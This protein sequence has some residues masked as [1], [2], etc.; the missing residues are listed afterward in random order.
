MINLERSNLG[1]YMFFEKLFFTCIILFLCL[2]ALFSLEDHVFRYAPETDVDSVAVAGSFNDW[3]AHSFVLDGPDS[4][5]TFYGQKQLPP[6]TH[7]YKF[8]IDSEHWITDPDN[9]RQE[10]DGYG[11]MNSVITID[12]PIIWLA[13]KYTAGS[14]SINLDMI[15]IDFSEA[16]WKYLPPYFQV[17]LTAA[18]GDIDNIMLVTDN[19][20][21][22]LFNRLGTMNNRT[23]WVLTARIDD[24]VITGHLVLESGD[25]MYFWNGSFS[26]SYSG[27]FD[28]N[29][30][31]FQPP[32]QAMGGNIIWYQIFIDRFY[33]GCP[34]NDIEDIVDDWAAPWYRSLDP[35]KDFWDEVWLRHFGGDIQGIIQKLP[36]LKE[37][38]VNS[39]YLSP[40]FESPSPHKYDITDYRHIARDYAITESLPS[41]E[42]LLDPE[43]WQWT[44][45]DQ[46]FF[47]FLDKCSDNGFTVMTDIAFN[48][49]GLDFPAFERALEGEKP[50]TEWYN[51]TSHDPLEYDSF[52]GFGGM[53]EFTEKHGG[54]HESLEEYLKAVTRRWMIG[55]GTSEKP[56]GITAWRLD[57][58]NQ[59]SAGFWNRWNTYVR[60]IHPE[61][62]TMGEYW[63]N[64]MT[65]LNEG[66]FNSITNYNFYPMVYDFFT[67]SIS[68]TSFISRLKEY[69]YRYPGHFYD[70]P[71]MLDSHDKPRV[72]HRLE[73]SFG[74]ENRESQLAALH[75]ILT[76]QFLY[77]QPPFLYYGTEVLMTGANDPFNRDPMWWKNKRNAQDSFFSEKQRLQTRNF[78]QE[79]ITLRKK[80]MGDTNMVIIELLPD[81]EYGGF[82]MNLKSG[83]QNFYGYFNYT[84]REKKLSNSWETFNASSWIHIDF[85]AP[86]CSYLKKPPV[87]VPPLSMSGY[88][89]KEKD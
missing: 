73:Q 24:P 29:L 46:L 59:I 42:K 17:Y 15:E 66:G 72:L 2:T 64:G 68:V 21:P 19:N 31:Q 84:G 34:E 22:L 57:T 82:Y 80:I 1:A 78:I 4:D 69:E 75:G 37:L 41:D 13:D 89:E 62:F 12:S 7:Y 70:L 26:S 32:D 55:T 76:F 27:C 38:G 36:Y 50:F 44:Q 54:F 40:V 61:A 14:G 35:E 25:M 58:A 45:S 87:S 28:L 5:G 83:E 51:I 77:P 65:G 33:N 18:P 48:H 88:L 11:G 53:P 63:D 86:H 10:P 47:D 6:G 60:S 67:N 74:H 79:L 81:E 85:T 52:A 49:S 30:R 9:P 39:L 20:Q 71:T 8:V 56:T 23:H 16:H 43:T 3:N